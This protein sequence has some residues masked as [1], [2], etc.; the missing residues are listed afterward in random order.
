M[1]HDTADT[2]MVPLLSPKATFFIVNKHLPTIKGPMHK[3]LQVILSSKLNDHSKLEIYSLVGSAI[4]DTILFM[5]DSMLFL[6]SFYAQNK[7][8]IRST[9]SINMA[10]KIM[11]EP[12]KNEEIYEVVIHI[13]YV[14]YIRLK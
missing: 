2:Y 9:L 14:R 1:S 6:N 13:T 11:E 7:Y 10:S 4:L 8:F 5:H 3:S 12:D